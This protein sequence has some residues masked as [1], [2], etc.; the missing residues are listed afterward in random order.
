MSSYS[1]D[2][3]D[4]E[5]AVRIT[6]AGCLAPADHKRFSLDALEEARRRSCRKFIADHRQAGLDFTFME[7]Y[8]WPRQLKQFGLESNM[9]VAVVYAGSDP[10]ARDYRFFEDV[11]FNQGLP[12]MRVFDDY[13]E[14]LKW[15]RGG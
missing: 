15:L 13:D 4:D 3:L 11:S 9:R 14:A 1:I 8:E 2:Y 6:T 5:K 7:I 10:K 12:L